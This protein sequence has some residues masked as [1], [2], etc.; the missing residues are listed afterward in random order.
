MRAR[1]V[2]K[3][4]IEL[5]GKAD[6]NQNGLPISLDPMVKLINMDL[7]DGRQVPLAFERPVQEHP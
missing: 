2:A 6:I 5:A 1:N 4:G 7:R 3:T